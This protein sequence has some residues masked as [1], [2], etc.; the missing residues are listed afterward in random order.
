MDWMPRCIQGD[1][2]DDRHL[3]LRVTTYLASWVFSSK[4]DINHLD[5]SLGQRQL[6]C[7]HDGA[8]RHGGLVAALPTRIAPASSSLCPMNRAVSVYRSAGSPCH[9][10]SN[11]RNQEILNDRIQK[12]TWF[13]KYLC[14]YVAVVRDLRCFE[15]TFLSLDADQNAACWRLPCGGFRIR[16]P[17]AQPPAECKGCTHA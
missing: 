6:G 12:R 1:G 7:L 14:Y 16:Y 2:R 5:P 10:R 13:M 15:I 11:L 4:V 8:C 9:S 17:P 3:I